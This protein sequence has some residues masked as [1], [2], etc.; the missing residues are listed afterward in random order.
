MADV[1]WDRVRERTAF[2]SE[3]GRRWLEKKRAE[4]HALPRGTVVIIDVASGEYVT[5]RTFLEANPIFDQ[6]FGASALGY[7]VHVGERTFIGGGIG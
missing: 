2:T 6:R 3:Q 4:I 5:G 1:N 7:T